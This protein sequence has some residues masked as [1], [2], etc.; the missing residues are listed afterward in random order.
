[1]KGQSTIIVALTA[2][3]FEE[4]REMISSAGCDDVVRKPFRKEEIF[5]MLAKHLG[6]RFIHS[7]ETAQPAA[8]PSASLQDALSPAALAALPPGWLS[9]LHQATIKANLTQILTLV[10]QIRKQNAPLADSLASLAQDFEYK[11]ILALIEQAG[12]QR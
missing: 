12:G 1:V 5:D 9:E 11:K 7:E 10:D 2:S 4:D 6:V 8:A 3:A